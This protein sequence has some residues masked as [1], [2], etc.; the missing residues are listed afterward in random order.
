MPALEEWLEP[1][2]SAIR[3][4]VLAP[5]VPPTMV[6]GPERVVDVAA[7][8]LH[9][10]GE[11]VEGIAADARPDFVVQGAMQAFQLA[12]RLRVANRPVRVICQRTT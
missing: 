8:A 1:F 7:P 9:V 12:L 3:D 4:A 5:A 6:V 11:V 10:G 2:P